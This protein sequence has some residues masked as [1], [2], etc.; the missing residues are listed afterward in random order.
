M[1]NLKH[2]IL[3]RGLP[4]SGKST[5]AENYIKENKNVVRINKDSLRTMLHFDNFSGKNESYTWEASKKLAEH[6]LSNGVSVI[7]DDTNLN[8]KT[9]S[10]WQQLAV[11]HK[12]DWYIKDFDTSVEECIERDAKRAKKVGKEVITSMALSSGYYQ[13]QNVVVCDID[14]TIANIKH[15]L[16]YAK[17]EDKNWKTFFSLVHLDV[18]RFEVARLVIDSLKKNDAKLIFV[19]ARPETIRPETEKWLKENILA[20]PEIAERY[21][22]LLMRKQ[23]DKRDD[24]EVKNDIYKKYLSAQRVVEVFDDR[25]KVIRMWRELGLNVTDVGNGEEF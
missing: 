17:G 1:T 19:S 25:P 16:K 24:T 23:N 7:I 5:W 9:V 3:L 22:C 13:L 2:L 11:E 20:H 8:P 21:L 18:P 14:G 12:A 10:M 15:R 4:A 6:F